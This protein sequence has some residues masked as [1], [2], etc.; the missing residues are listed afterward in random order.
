VKFVPHT[1]KRS[2]QRQF[3]NWAPSYDRS[4]LQ[5]LVFR[6]SYRA[7]LEEL[8]RWRLDDPA[9]FDLLDVGCGTGTWPAMVAATPL[10]GRRLFGL[11]YSYSMCQLASHKAREVGE[12]RMAFFNGDAEH[13]PFAD[14]SFDLLTC[15]NSFHH[16]PHQAAVVREFRRVLRPGGRLMIIDGFRDNLIGWIAFDV[17]VTRAEGNVHHAPWSQMRQYF[18]DAGFAQIVQRK[19][20][21]WIPLFIT[22]GVA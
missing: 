4:I 2:A 5:R 19:F 7:F 3:E 15:S 20:N 22:V 13:L 10:P 17:L 12:P 21:I 6:P 11:D 9:P 14:G 18:Q 8:V 1:T 16:Y